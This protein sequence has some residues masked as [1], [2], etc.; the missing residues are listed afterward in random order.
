[1]WYTERKSEG[2]RALYKKADLYTDA[3]L[4]KTKED[5][6]TFVAPCRARS[7]AP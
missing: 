2:V 4:H 6:G 1:V 7:L 5:P 3:L